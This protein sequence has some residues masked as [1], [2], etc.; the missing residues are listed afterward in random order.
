MFRAIEK[1][2]SFAVKV[3]IIGFIFAWIEEAINRLT[4]SFKNI[5]RDSRVVKADEMEKYY[6]IHGAQCSKCKCW[7]PVEFEKCPVC[8]SKGMLNTSPAVRNR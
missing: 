7:I 3:L 2:L 5:G 1:I 4:Q 8:R 6:M